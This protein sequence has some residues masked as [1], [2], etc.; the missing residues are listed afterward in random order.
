MS[1]K[2]PKPDTL[3]DLQ[4]FVWAGNFHMDSWKFNRLRKFIINESNT[5]EDRIAALNV[6]DIGIGE[7]VSPATAEDVAE[8]VREAQ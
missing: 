4:K 6:L 5:M 2:T 8:F 1:K 3:A 7:E